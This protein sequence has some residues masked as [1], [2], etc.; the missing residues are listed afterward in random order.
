MPGSVPLP[1]L[2]T[3]FPTKSKDKSLGL[4]KT[5]TFGSN[6]STKKCAVVNGVS[7]VPKY[8]FTPQKYSPYERTGEVV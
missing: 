8:A 3:R 5:A 4:D 2:K 7:V 1:Q 6:S